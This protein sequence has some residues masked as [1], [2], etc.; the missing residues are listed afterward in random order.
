MQNHRDLEIWQ[1]GMT[2]AVEIYR[3]SADLP[4]AE[5]YN[6]ASQ[7]RRAAASVPLNIAEGAASHSPSEF[8]HFLSYAY[9]SLKEVATAL[10][11]C[12]RL[13]SMEIGSTVDGLIA[14]GDEIA[15]MVYALSQRVGG[16]ARSRRAEAPTD[17]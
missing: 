9:R 2:Y 14:Q 16:R 11:L 5:R 8:A 17:H 15:R 12:K 7:L 6:L 4:D 10:E 1:R 3:F 13:Y